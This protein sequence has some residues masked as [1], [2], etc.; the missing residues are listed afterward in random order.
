MVVQP[1]RRSKCQVKKNR[2]MTRNGLILFIAV[3]IVAFSCGKSPTTQSSIAGKWNVISDSLYVGVGLDNRLSVYSGK[4]GD[5][6][7]F[8]AGG[9]IQMNEG[10]VLAIST[11][12]FNKDSVF[13]YNFNGT[14][15]GKGRFFPSS[16]TLAITTGYFYTPGG[17]IGRTVHLAR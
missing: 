17:A 14:L 6:F 8:A 3:S 4:P 10:I 13:I 15:P 7:D 11:F 2:S 1:I 5:F 12:T 16:D 9:S